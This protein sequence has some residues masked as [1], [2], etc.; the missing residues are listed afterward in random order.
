MYRFVLS[1]KRLELTNSI[2]RLKGGLDRLI[3]ANEAVEE[4]KI[5]LKDMQPQ[6]EKASIDTLKMMEKLKVDKAE[7][8]E[9]QKVVAKEEAQATL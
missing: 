9:T 5:V 6:L 2:L 3:A 7:A 1:E 8:D 4:I